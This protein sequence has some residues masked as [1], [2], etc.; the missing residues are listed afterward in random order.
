MSVEQAPRS[1]PGTGDG[2]T[3][4]PPLAAVDG[5]Y[6]DTRM[7]RPPAPSPLV[8]MADFDGP[9]PS[10]DDVMERIELLCREAKRRSR[11]PR[12]DR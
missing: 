4:A 1:A 7:A 6:V 2:R 12:L 10:L 8:L 9:P 5:T 3:A 11:D